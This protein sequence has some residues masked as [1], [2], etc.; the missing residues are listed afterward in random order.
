MGRVELKPTMDLDVAR[1]FGPAA[2]AAYAQ[3]VEARA[4]ALADMRARHSSV[5]D[6]IDI[7]THAHGIHHSVVMSV[8]GR[9]GVEIASALEFGHFNRWLEHRYGIHHP[10]AWIPGMFI[11]TEAK[12]G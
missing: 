2:T 1:L 3:R 10:L 9:N 12:Y 8:T 4:K 7:A 11:M 5:A 6:R